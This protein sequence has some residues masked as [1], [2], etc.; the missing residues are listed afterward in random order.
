[1]DGSGYL[2]MELWR[3]RIYLMLLGALAVVGGI[4]VLVLPNTTARFDLLGS[5][6]IIGGLAMFIVAV[7]RDRPS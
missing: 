3:G 4:L 7:I 1:L 6:A 2:I 5:V